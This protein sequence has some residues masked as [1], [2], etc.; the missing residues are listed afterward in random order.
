VGAEVHRHV[1]DGEAE[2]GPVVEVEAAQE[3]LVGLAPARMLGGDQSGRGL[4]DLARAQQRAD[5]D[6]GP[7]DAALAGRAGGADAPL[8]AAEDE[9]RAG[10]RLVRRFRCRG[11]D[12]RAVR[13]SGLVRRGAVLRQR[14]QGGGQ[15]ERGDTAGSKAIGTAVAT[16]GDHGS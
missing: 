7:G 9:D 14:R 1:I 11:V 16:H 12:R 8:A 6:V 4:E 5:L 13:R 10:N 15:R 3:V 2:V